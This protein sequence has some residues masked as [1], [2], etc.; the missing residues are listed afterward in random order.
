MYYESYLQANLQLFII[1]NDGIPLDFKAVLRVG[2]VIISCLSLF[3]GL[4]KMDL[5]KL[6]NGEIETV[7]SIK[8]FFNELLK[9]IT[10]F[11]RVLVCFSLFYVHE[12]LLTCA[13]IYTCIDFLP[14][15][16]LLFYFLWCVRNNKDTLSNIKY[17]FGIKSILDPSR[18]FF[19]DKYKPDD[20][21]L[22]VFR[23]S[24]LTLWYSLVGVIFSSIFISSYFSCNSSCDQ[25]VNRLSRFNS[26]FIFSLVIYVVTFLFTITTFVLAWFLEKPLFT[27]VFQKA[28][29][30]DEE[31]KV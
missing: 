12:D 5:I 25:F 17:L 26:F 29:I 30:I 6:S 7:L 14:M 22:I 15:M 18:I 24:F 10:I 16:L 28:E 3:Y 31:T 23:Y 11:L 13:I 1:I 4:C 9:K 27:P 20:W 21:N 2:G 19:K 8:L